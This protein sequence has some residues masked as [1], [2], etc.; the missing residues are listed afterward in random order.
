MPGTR[1]LVKLSLARHWKLTLTFSQDARSF[2]RARNSIA[3]T[4]LAEIRRNSQISRISIFKY[5]LLCT[6]LQKFVKYSMYLNNSS[7]WWPWIRKS[8]QKQHRFL[9]LNIAINAY[10]RL[11]TDSCLNHGYSI[12]IT[13]TNWSWS[14]PNIWMII[15][16]HVSLPLSLIR[17]LLSPLILRLLIYILSLLT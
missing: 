14:A 3:R 2:L 8:T 16:E 11:L 4:Y 15:N 5:I 6:T 7:I 10:D 13:K 9:L 1:M 17:S 12:I